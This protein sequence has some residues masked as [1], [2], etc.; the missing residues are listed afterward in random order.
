MARIDRSR[1]IQQLQS[2]LDKL[3]S[4]KSVKIDDLPSGK[5]RDLAK[6]VGPR[7]TVGSGCDTSREIT[8]N[9]TTSK[10]KAAVKRVAADLKR[11]DKDKDNFVSG[12][13]T[14]GLSKLSKDLLGLDS[15][16]NTPVA[17]GCVY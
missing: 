15:A 7:R 2:Q 8:G 13:E 4:K 14:K 10:L 17:S 6:L 12:T 3:G 1:T 16:G 9:V 5:L 11:A